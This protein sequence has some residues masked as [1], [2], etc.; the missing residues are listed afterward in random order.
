MGYLTE[1][2]EKIL[3]LIIEGYISSAEPIGSRTISK[4]INNKWS[5][6]TIR[7]V[8][9]DLEEMGLLYRPHAMAGRIPTSKAFRYYVDS[10]HIPEY[11]EKKTLQMVSRMF[12]LRYS[13]VE[14]VMEDASRALA[15]LSRYTSI[16]VEPKVNT[17]RFKEVEFV[18][19]SATTVLVVFVTSSGMVHTRFVDIEENLDP[20]TL[21]EMKDYMNGRFEG[22]PFY[23]LQNEIAEDIK[24]DRTRFNQLLA[25][26]NE[27]I[28]AIIASE[29][30]REIYIDGTSRMMDSPEFSDMERLKELFKTL[31]RKEKLLRLIDKSLEEKGLHVFLGIE[32][33]I[34]EMKDMSII[35]STYRITDSSFGVL[36][37]IGPMRMNYSKII[38]IV[39]YTART[40]TDILKII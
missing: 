16:V 40:V 33:D 20:P 10:L 18:K 24:N 23:L 14:G 30:K 38:P 1:R 7:S 5:A 15:E 26:I 22:I 11:P 19:L 4:M 9:A 6:A 28:E 21:N 17:M 2:E 8:M 35:T 3:Q 34:K 13:Y 29:E 12:K 31:E 37:V 39:D 27:T 36:G 25:K 32:S